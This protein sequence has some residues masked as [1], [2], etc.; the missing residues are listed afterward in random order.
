M[1]PILIYGANGFTGRLVTEAALARGHTPIVAGRHPQRVA[2]L[3]RRL[4]LPAR[5]F[6][7][8]NPKE[9]ARYLDGVGAVIHC[10]GPFSATASPMLDACL[11][12][13]AHYLDI[14]GEIDVFEM[15]HGR[16]AEVQRAGICAVPGVGFDVVPSDCLAALLKEKLPDA[17]HLT[18]AFDPR[19]AALSV[20]T[21]K[22]MVEGLGSG[23]RVRIGGTIVEEIPGERTRVVP[24]TPAGTL[25]M[26]I[27]WGDV[28]TAYHSTGIPNVVVYAATSAT[29]LR[30]VRFLHYAR[31]L[32]ALA[33][34]QLLLK[35][36]IQRRI[37]GPTVAAR[38]QATIHLWGEAKNAAG[39]TAQ[40]WMRTPEGYT[41]TAGAAVRAAERLL[42]GGTAPGFHTPSS[43]FGARFVT[44]LPGVLV[45]ETPLTIGRDKP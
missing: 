32:L 43:A 38:G 17:T 28:S 8:R 2:N 15:V 18:L 25:A 11:A 36:Q 10:A 30:L 39:A 22:T 3:A 6:D 27:P 12:A 37:Q 7:L 19:G 33:P 16:H 31:W 35:A 29:Q 40:L 4:K 34:V 5:I 9:A 45:S 21:A 44:E 24:L 41:L 20:G 13:K 26:A 42:A 1:K 14:T 23:G